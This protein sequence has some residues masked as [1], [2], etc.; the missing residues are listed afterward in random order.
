M[1]SIHLGQD[2]ISQK[3]IEKRIEKEIDGSGS[4]PGIG[5]TSK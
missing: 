2:I 4:Q 3:G 5:E 1:L